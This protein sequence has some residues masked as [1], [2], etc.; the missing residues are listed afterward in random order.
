MFDTVNRALTIF[1]VT[2]GKNGRTFS[3]NYHKW[4]SDN[5]DLLM[6]DIEYI[7]NAL[8]TARVLDTQVRRSNRAND[9]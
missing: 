2:A 8:A 6:Q 5:R 4:T 9:S 1:T 3:T 7:E